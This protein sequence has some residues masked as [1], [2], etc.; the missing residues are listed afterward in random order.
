MGKPKTKIKLFLPLLLGF[1]IG[2]FFVGSIALALDVGLDYGTYTGLGTEDIRVSVMKIVRYFLGF[3]GIIALI[4]IIYGGFVWMTSA[5]NPEKVTLAKRILTSAVIGLVIILSAF[6]IVSFIINALVDTFVDPQTPICTPGDTQTCNVDAD[7]IGTQ[8]C[9][10]TGFWGSCIPNEP[11]SPECTNFISQAPN[12]FITTPQICQATDTI[13]EA[14]TSDPD[15]DTV[16]IEFTYISGV[17][18]GLIGSVNGISTPATI[19]SPPWDTSGFSIGQI[20]EVTAEVTDG[21]NS[22]SHARNF[23]I[24]AG[25]CC[26]GVQDVDEDGVDCGG[27]DC[28]GCS[29]ADCDLGD[30]DPA[31]CL[32]PENYNCYSLFCDPTGCT[33]QDKPMIFWVSP[34]D[35][36]SGNLVTIGGRYFGSIPGEVWFSGS[37]APAELADA[38]NPNCDSVWTDQQIIVVVPNDVSDGPIR[39]V[40]KT[41]GQDYEDQTNDDYGP[42][43]P[44]FD[45]NSIVRPGLCSVVNDNT[46]DPEGIF[47]DPLELQGINFSSG[48]DVF[49]G[50]VLSL[51]TPVVSGGLTIT[52]VNVPNVQP[53]P[54]IGTRVRDGG[55]YSNPVGFKVNETGKEPII[56]DFDPA[57]G[58]AGTYVTITGANF[59]TNRQ[60]VNGQ[61]YFE[62]VGIYEAEYDF[63]PEC[64]DSY[65]SDG[66]VVVKVPEG[67]NNASYTIRLSN[68]LGSASSEDS[69]VAD[70]GVVRPNICAVIPNNG[71]IDQNITI[72][73][74]G[75]FSPDVNQVNFYQNIPQ[76]SLTLDQIDRPDPE[77][78]TD[79]TKT[80]VPVS[81]LTGPVNIQNSLGNQSNSLN[82]IVGECLDDSGCETNY[83]CCLGGMYKGSCMP[84]GGCVGVATEAAYYWSF[85]TGLKPGPCSKDVGVCDPDNTLCDPGFECNSVTCECQA[86]P[87]FDCSKQPYPTCDP[88]DTLCNPDQYC[89]SN[90]TCQDRIACDGEELT[91]I[92]DPDQDICRQTLGNNWYCYDQATY[93][94]DPDKEDCYCYQGI[95]CD[96]DTE[97]FHYICIGGT[98]SGDFCDDGSGGSDPSI[99]DSGVCELDGTAPICDPNDDICQQFDANWVCGT[100][101]CIC[102]PG[103][104]APTEALYFWNFYSFSLGPQVVNECNRNSECAKVCALD[105]EKTCS[106]DSD[107]GA[108]GPCIKAFSSPTPLYSRDGEVYRNSIIS[109]SFDK[110]VI[111]NTIN[112][113]NIIIKECNVGTVFDPTSCSTVI[114]GDGDLDI[115]TWNYGLTESEGFIFT[116]NSPLSPNTWYQITLTQGIIGENG[117]PLGH[118]PNYTWEFKVLNTSNNGDIGCV[119]CQ[120]GYAVLWS[121][122]DGACDPDDLDC[123]D[124]IGSGWDQDNVCVM[125]DPNSYTWNWSLPTELTLERASILDDTS[126][127]PA[128]PNDSSDIILS[129]TTDETITTYS[130][131]EADFENPV[132]VQVQVPGVDDQA[133]FYGDNICEL[134]IDFSTPVVLKRWPDC[135][136][137][138]INAAMGAAFSVSIDPTTMTAG[139]VNSSMV[140][141]N[142]GDNPD[143]RPGYGTCSSSGTYCDLSLVGSDCPDTGET[144]LDNLHGIYTPTVIPLSWEEMGGKINGW[145]NSWLAATN[146][147]DLDGDGINDYCLLPNTYYKVILHDSIRGLADGKK[148]GGLNYCDAAIGNCDGS[149]FDSYT[150]TF[151]TQGSMCSPDRVRVYPEENWMRKEEINRYRSSAYASPDE[152]DP[153]GQPL[154]SSSFLWEWQSTNCQTADLLTNLELPFLNNHNIWSDPWTCTS[155]GTQGNP[156]FNNLRNGCGNGFIGQGEECDDGNVLSG[157]GCSDICLHEGSVS[158]GDF[159]EFNPFSGSDII[160]LDSSAVNIDGTAPFG[161]GSNLTSIFIFEDNDDSENILG[162]INNSPAGGTSSVAFNIGY[163]MPGTPEIVAFDDEQEYIYSKNY[164]FWEWDGGSDGALIKL[165]NDDW[166]VSISPA[167]WGGGNSW[168]LVIDGSPS[169]ISINTDQY[170]VVAKINGVYR[171]VISDDPIAPAVCG[172]GEVEIGEDCDDGNN[173]L[174]PLTGDYCNEN[175]LWAGNT[176]TFSVCGNGVVEP[177]EECDNGDEPN[178][179]DYDG[180]TNVCTNSGSV[181]GVS[182]CGDGLVGLGEECDTFS[183]TSPVSGDGCTGLDDPGNLCSNFTNELDCQ[184]N[185]KFCRWSANACYIRPCLD[186]S[187][188][189]IPNT[190]Y[191]LA[192]CG[193]GILESGEECDYGGVC[194]NS[195]GN[196]VTCS[197]HTQYSVCSSG[198]CGNGSCR[199][200]DDPSIWIDCPATQAEIDTLCYE[201]ICQAPAGFNSSVPDCSERCLNTGSVSDGKH[202][203]L[204]QALYDGETEIQSW[205]TIASEIVGWGDL[206]VGFPFG[207]GEFG[208]ID[209]WPDCSWACINAIIGAQFSLSANP[210][211]ITDTGFN[212]NPNSPSDPSDPGDKIL[213]YQCGKDE[214]CNVLN[215]VGVNINVTPDTINPDNPDDKFFISLPINY[216][217]VD[218]DNNPATPV[219]PTLVPGTFYRVVIR[220][221][222]DGVFS[223]DGKELKGLNFDDPLYGT[224]SG[225]DSYSWVFETQEEDDLCGLDHVEVIPKENTLPEGNVRSR[226]F[227]QPWSEP[228]QCDSRGQRL[229]PY[230]FQWVWQ[231]VDIEGINAA[232]F[233]GNGELDGCGNGIVD[234]GEDCDNGVVSDPKCS[235]S[236]EW[237]GNEYCSEVFQLD[238]CGNE[239]L[240]YGEECEIDLDNVQVYYSLEDNANDLMGNFDG[241]VFGDVSFN[242]GRLGQAAVFD[243]TPGEYIQIDNGLGQMPNTLK[244]QNELTVSAWVKPVSG[245]DGIGRVVATTY[246]HDCATCNHGGWI[247]GDEWGSDDS[248]SFVIWDNDG[249]NNDANRRIVS[250]SGFFTTFNNEWVHVAGVY[251]RSKGYISLYINGELV[252]QRLTSNFS[253]IGYDQVT[254]LRIGHRA[255]NETQGPWDGQIDDV[256]IY[257][258]ALSGIEIRNLANNFYCDGNCLAT[259][260]ENLNMAVCGN[261]IIEETEECDQGNEPNGNDTDGCTDVCR[262]SGSIPGV[263]SLCGDGV[264]GPGEECDE[265]EL[266]NG[267]KPVHLDD[268]DGDGIGCTG[269][270]YDNDAKYCVGGSNGGDPCNSNSDCDSN[271]CEPTGVV[272]QNECEAIDFADPNANPVCWCSWTGS[273]CQ[274]RPCLIEDRNLA[275]VCRSDRNNEFDFT[276]DPAECEQGYTAESLEF[277][278]GNANWD[279]P[280]CGNN[281]VEEGEQCDDGSWC[282]IGGDKW[283]RCNTYN[284]DKCEVPNSCKPYDGFCSID[285]SPC[286]LAPGGSLT[287]C[288]A[289]G[290]CDGNGACVT[291]NNNIPYSAGAVCGTPASPD[292]FGTACNISGGSCISDSCGINCTFNQS[293]AYDNMVDPYQVIQTVSIGVI[294]ALE[295]VKEEIR[296]WYNLQPDRVGVGELTVVSGIS[297]PFAVI[298]HKPPADTV[299]AG[300]LECRNVVLAATFSKPLKS[301]NIGDKFKLHLCSLGTT[302]SYASCDTN[303]NYIAQT[304]YSE[305]AG[306]CIDKTCHFSPNIVDSANQIFGACESDLECVASRVIVSEMY[307]YCSNDN[308]PCSLNSDCGSGN[309]CLSLGFL[310]P[311][312]SY[313]LVIDSSLEDISDETLGA[314]CSATDTSCE[315]DF[316]AGPDFCDCDYISLVVNPTSGGNETNEDYFTCAADNCGSATLTEFDDDVLDSALGNQHLWETTC[317][318][319]NNPDGRRIEISPV[320][321]NFNWSEFDPDDLIYFTDQS[322]GDFYNNKHYISPGEGDPY[323]PGTPAGKN[324]ESEVFIT[325]NQYYCLDSYQFCD[326][327]NASSCNGVQENCVGILASHKLVGVTNF[328]CDNPWPAAPNFPY[329]DNEDNGVSPDTNFKLFYCRDAGEEG[330]SDDLPALSLD[331]A[332][333]KGRGNVVKEFIFPSEGF[334]KEIKNEMDGD[335]PG[336]VDPSQS[337]CKGGSWSQLLIASARHASYCYNG[338]NPAGADPNYW[339][340]P[341]TADNFDKKGDYLL[342]ITTFSQSGDLSTLNYCDNNSDG[343]LKSPEITPC[344]PIDSNP[345]SSVGD[346]ITC[347]TG[348]R[349]I[350]KVFVDGNEVGQISNL[351]TDTEQVGSVI[352][353]NLDLGFH[354]V[355]IYWVNDWNDSINGYDSNLAISHIKLSRI[356]GAGVI[357]DAIGVRVLKNPL[358]LSPQTWYKSGLCGGGADFKNICFD[359][360]DCFQLRELGLAGY[361]SFDNDSSETVIDSSGNNFDGAVIGN[362]VISKMGKSWRFDGVDDGIDFGDIFDLGTDKSLTFSAWIKVEN[363]P[364]EHQDLIVGKK[365]NLYYYTTYYGLYVNK[366]GT[367]C[368][369]GITLS[370]GT[371][372]PLTSENI[373]SAYHED[374]L[375]DSEWHHVAGVIDRDNRKLRFY[376]DGQ[377]DSSNGNKDINGIL[378][379][380]DFSTLDFPFLIGKTYTVGAGDGPFDGYI[381]DVRVYDRALTSG[382]IQSLASR[383]YS[384]C[385]MNVPAQGSPSRTLTDNYYSIKDGRTV[386][387]G[388]TNRDL[389]NSE[390]YSNIYLLSYSQNSSPEIKEIFSRILDPNQQLGVWS[391]NTDVTNHRVCDGIGVFQGT[392]NLCTNLG[393]TYFSECSSYTLDRSSQGYV[394]SNGND[395]E[396]P[397]T[398]SEFNLPAVFSPDVGYYHPFN[399]GYVVLW[400]GS[401][402]WINDGTP[403]WTEVSYTTPTDGL[404]ANFDPEVGYYNDLA[405]GYVILWDNDQVYVADSSGTFDG[406]HDATEY[407]LPAGFSPDVGYY[408]PFDGGYV[409]LW[410]GDQAYIADSSGMFDGPHDATEYGLPP[411]FRPDVGYY[412]DFDGGRVALIDGSEIYVHDGTGNFDGPYNSEDFGLSPSIAPSIGY[413][414]PIDGGRVIIFENLSAGRNACNSDYVHG[415]YWSNTLNACLSRVCQPTYC[416]SDFDC[417]NL[418]CNAYK[419]EIVRD[420]KRYNDL[421]DIQILLESYAKQNQSYPVL[422]GGTYIPETS[423]STWPSWQI[424]LGQE[425]GSGLFTDPI[426]EMRACSTF[427]CDQNG[428]GVID[429]DTETGSFAQSCTWGNINDCNYNPFACMPADPDQELTCWD[430]VNENFTCPQEM[431]TYGY[432]PKAGGLDYGLYTFMEYDG[433]GNWR[434]ASV[435][436]LPTNLVNNAAGKCSILNFEIQSAPLGS[437]NAATTCVVKRCYGG[438]NNP[439]SP[440]DP[441]VNA[442]NTVSDCPDSTTPGVFCSGDADGDGV[443]DFGFTDNC[444]PATVAACQDN[445]SAC[446]NPN[447]RDTNSDGTGDVCDPNCSGDADGDGVC[448]EKDGCRTVANCENPALG[449]CNDCLGG[450]F[451]CTDNR[452][453]DHDNDEIPDACDPCTDIDKDGWWDYPTG[454]NDENICPRDNCAAGFLGV[455]IDNQGNRNGQRCDSSSMPCNS[456]YTCVEPLSTVANDRRKYCYLGNIP[457]PVSCDDQSDCN[458][459]GLS[460]ASCTQLSGN[461]TYYNPFQEDYD[462]DGVG[463]ICDTCIDFDNDNLGDYTFYTH[464]EGKPEYITND[465]EKHFMGCS[466]KYDEFKS[467]RPTRAMLD[468]NRDYNINNDDQ[469]DFSQWLLDGKPYPC[470]L[471]TC[472]LDKNGSV[473]NGDVTEWGNLKAILDTNFED[474][475]DLDNCPGGPF[476]ADCK[477]EFGVE[478]SCYNPP[479]SSWVDRFGEAHFNAQMDYDQDLLGSVCDPIGELGGSGT[480]VDSCGDGVVDAKYG[481]ICDCGSTFTSP[482]VPLNQDTSILSICNSRNN[483]PC[484]APY[485]GSCQWCSNCTQ[486]KIVD[487]GFCGDNIAQWPNEVCDDGQDPTN[488]SCNDT[489]TGWGTINGITSPC[490]DDINNYNPWSLE[491]SDSLSGPWSGSYTFNTNDL[492]YMS[493]PDCSTIFDNISL[494]ITGS[495]DLAYRPT[496]AVVFVTDLSGSMGDSMTELKISLQ[497]AI[498]SLFDGLNDTVEVGLVSYSSSA[499]KD[500]SS[501]SNFLCDNTEESVLIGSRSNNSDGIV[502]NYDDGGATRTDQAVSAAEE[503]LDSVSGFDNKFM[504]VM[505]DGG[506]SCRGNDCCGG[507]I[508]CASTPAGC[509]RVRVGGCGLLGLL[510]DYEFPCN[511]TDEAQTARSGGLTIYSV[512]YGGDVATMN[513]VSSNSEIGVST[514]DNNPEHYCYTSNT[515]LTGMYTTIV[516][517]IINSQGGVSLNLIVNEG[518]SSESSETFTVSGNSIDFNDGSFS[519]TLNI[520]FSSTFCENQTDPTFSV[521]DINPVCTNGTPLHG[522]LSTCGPSVCEVNVVSVDPTFHYCPTCDADWD[523]VWN[524]FCNGPDCNDNDPNIPSAE[525]CDDPFAVDE[526]CDGAINC[527]DTD[528]ASLPICESNFSVSGSKGKLVIDG[529]IIAGAFDSFFCAAPLPPYYCD[530]DSDGRFSKKISGRASP[531]PSGCQGIIG[532]DCDDTNEN[533]NPGMPELCGSGLDED[534][535]GD[536]D[537]DDIDCE[538]DS[539]C[540]LPENCSNGLDDDEDGYVDCADFD[541]TGSVDG[542]GRICCGTSTGPDNNLCNTCQRCVD[543]TTEEEA[544]SGERG[545][546]NTND[547]LNRCVNFNSDEGINCTGDSCTRCV[548]GSCV[549]RSDFDGT[550]CTGTDEVCL[551]G[552]CQVVSCIPGQI[553]DCPLTQGVCAG[554]QQN[555]VAG[556]WSICDAATYGPDYEATETSCNDGLDND[557]DGDTDTCQDSDCPTE[558]TEVSCTDTINNDCDGDADCADSD[559]SADPACLTCPDSVCE[560]GEV[561]SLDC[562]TET[563]CSDS[564]D[565]DNDG[566]QDTADSDCGGS[567]IN[568]V[569]SVDNDCDGYID[570]ADSN[571]TGDPACITCPNGTCAE[572]E[573]CSADC[574]TE[575]WC[576]DNVDNDN[577]TCED[578]VDVDCGGTETSCNDT[579]D[580]DCDGNTDCADPDCSGDPACVTCPNGTC[581]FGEICPADCTEDDQCSDGEDNDSNGCTDSQ[582]YLCGGTETSCNDTNDNDCDGNTDCADPDCSGDPACLATYTLSTVKLGTGL[583]DVSSVPSGINCGP[584]CMEV[585]TEGTSVTLSATPDG[586]SIFSG[587]TGGGCSGTGDCIF[588]INNDT[589]I[590]ATFDTITY[591]LSVSTSGSGSVSSVPSGIN[592]GADCSEAYNISTNVNLTAVPGGSSF[593]VNWSGDCSGTD[594]SNCS[595]TMNSNHNVTANFGSC[596]DSDSDGYSPEGGFCGLT[597]CN[598]DPII[599]SNI[600]PTNS[601]IYCDCAGTYSQG[602]TE[603]CDGVDNDCDGDV[604]EGCAGACTIGQ[605]TSCSSL[606]FAGVCASPTATCDSATG[607]WDVSPCQIGT[608][609]I[610]DD[611]LDN[612]CMNGADCADLSCVGSAGPTGDLC[613]LDSGDCNEYNGNCVSKI[614]DVGN[615]NTCS[616]QSQNSLCL[617]NCDQCVLSG[618]SYNCQANSSLC[619]GDCAVC[620]E[621]NSVNFTCEGN[622]TLCSGECDWCDG[623]GTNFTCQNVAANT[624]DIYGNS[625][626]LCSDTEGYGGCTPPCYCNSSGSCIAGSDADNDGLVDDFDPCPYDPNNDWDTANIASVNDQICAVGC[627]WYSGAPAPFDD[628]S[629]IKNNGYICAP[630]ALV[631]YD[632]C[633]GGGVGECN[634]TNSCRVWF[635]AEDFLNIYSYNSSSGNEVLIAGNLY[636]PDGFAT[637][638]EVLGNSTPI[639]FIPNIWSSAGGFNGSDYKF[640]FLARSDNLFVSPPKVGQI[641]GSFTNYNSNGEC[642]LLSGLIYK[643]TKREEMPLYCEGLLSVS[644][645]TEGSSA[646][647]NL[648]MTP[649]TPAPV[650]AFGN[651]EEIYCQTW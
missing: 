550:E 320:G 18:G 144:C 331:A 161:L 620:Q 238:C 308:K 354:E 540:V 3:L 51:G 309:E 127:Q 7:C 517:N 234:A 559:C 441:T 421:R 28:I 371:V 463:Y 426:N 425:L 417:P 97:N 106:D 396:G 270:Y 612:D 539:L 497:N 495:V 92:C 537:C 126:P 395:F 401:S 548:N 221:G 152:C 532:D 345:C 60:Q 428:N 404:P 413:Y 274:T 142:C 513:T 576:S 129:L 271:N 120:P 322:V 157:D 512:A 172:N 588:T 449:I 339:S 597:D 327:L 261:G 378:N 291:N 475:I 393:S 250:D 424:T 223:A 183:G 148:L 358:R 201:N 39:I 519:T 579:N 571:C 87:T 508:G 434:D 590:S 77:I 293:I 4:I 391:F 569:D 534:C 5:G 163:N 204:V 563:W 596:S 511:P 328:I 91:P 300:V 302:G 452:Q 32:T 356:E 602:T 258:K 279:L 501:C 486:V 456:G 383:A 614:C 506:C 368:R 155:T 364:D 575:T 369:S 544:Y 484:P 420:S 42:F 117:F 629:G 169:L 522:G 610:C 210:D 215:A 306:S 625:G 437:T 567:E 332:V 216:N 574:I 103:G 637:E 252:D 361:W 218:H 470:P 429:L 525:I 465:Q 227:S 329:Y 226:Y 195:W 76:T 294:P 124:Y 618:N 71:P 397:Y 301:T 455:C 323:D 648:W 140:V 284:R 468:F 462:N 286:N 276:Q 85:T 533:I 353:P 582:D 565:N 307:G 209:R 62:G 646:T 149:E 246:N 288:T 379:N 503:I 180:C 489:C 555:C 603:T 514:C 10:G 410:Q 348:V 458:A 118:N 334:K 362:P 134:L 175:C 171:Y 584:D 225:V 335:N 466:S 418:N 647:E 104:P 217:P 31:T 283:M 170:L 314:S 450:S 608:I 580:N 248:F 202:N 178:Y 121:R 316:S 510:D 108:D 79:L 479:I 37:S 296:A 166:L 287:P 536:I 326:P 460:G 496:T 299:P 295:R 44:D 333:I 265:G 133:Y 529:G 491:F 430:E 469:N 109:A 581:E 443:C 57:N 440:S 623:S 125:L 143:C 72:Y 264:V 137:A 131:F 528:C 381:D 502:G 591:I 281:I 347:I 624:Q 427:F 13:I 168:Q 388:A 459:A 621:V 24:R 230:F 615:T 222:A 473:D 176:D 243:A 188:T 285:A 289:T 370:D 206:T 14:V 83:E 600:Y 606:G 254:P 392:D 6:M 213:L 601:N 547:D 343:I 605:T 30:T 498:I 263:D 90:C 350:L 200:K 630:G 224:S 613:C 240:E 315:W 538:F 515:D 412:H 376:L 611:N 19:N 244:Y 504:I 154:M 628:G 644:G 365:Q 507:L 73:G 516:N 476:G 321:I 432:E 319:T 650:W 312:S 147:Y 66:Q 493:A 11:D 199:K 577:D 130:R 54:M 174:N 474:E 20:V 45:L 122:Y 595:L 84:L 36:A 153:E 478:V 341:F 521:K 363:C 310:A 566:C 196:L 359:N 551:G 267:D 33:C 173:F 219:Q 633:Q 542:S 423:F 63:P 94:V 292:A 607:N 330:F 570:C 93:G 407:G 115:F 2:S 543:D 604:D 303:N 351:A 439:G 482:F 461:Y 262:F 325:A 68:N 75:F 17:S 651:P 179:D 541:C 589:S 81:S 416:E 228:D 186:E 165:T 445:P 249:N 101:T 649:L 297:V 636:L 211:D 414:H 245:P 451:G 231:D 562:T 56:Y 638:G 41:T 554:S 477:D 102:E 564:V 38:V 643:R 164:L 408:H 442:C 313:H 220:G 573:V 247:L 317:Y 572:G 500:S 114:S 53:A 278:V 52:G 233:I 568:C 435:Y 520:D 634:E 241:Q 156:N 139:N 561:C 74:E 627:G 86:K 531:A 444:N 253:G 237:I 553:Q 35:G 492:V 212:Y 67:I 622:H 198:V 386:Y 453:I 626:Q 641:R 394:S 640:T 377:L 524:A 21:D 27:A 99:C 100:D 447:Q 467:F 340:P 616:Y 47:E 398:P 1:V 229:N 95:P 185:D 207:E 158:I 399:G 260:N 406:P 55:E 632:T 472:D 372:P 190:N 526:D 26:N 15:L 49:L 70:S 403:G 411:G 305:Y 269:I 488:P 61:V 141:Y 454:A 111:D 337:V 346:D 277:V 159:I 523:G 110:K 494:N 181:P 191:S 419:E 113:S 25:H 64:S 128:V 431:L 96:L 557:C 239:D 205:T 9:L 400:Q 593:F 355:K 578:G 208:V 242:D 360:N 631:S 193:N 352:L 415:C 280:I 65:W 123:Q 311:N 402:A 384:Q 43:L 535:D 483:L 487:G 282:G 389:D 214:T 46:G 232:D 530:N 304:V 556:T 599:G 89:D 558:P 382:E 436:D 257:N 138:C 336:L 290:Y 324:G 266:V 639:Y 373:Q 387:V 105:R 16:N 357:N 457:Y 594:P 255:D 499:S 385:V 251:S 194:V 545:S 527:Q 342:E 268:Y 58:A 177:G 619:I 98:N 82:F 8:S 12:V 446:Y 116:P 135:G 509:T 23:S 197:T 273:N 256:K 518:Q 34:N 645:G 236:C 375:D 259:G 40:E 405:G 78:D 235:S 136:A 367:S 480:I 162:I 586:T 485:N 167:F 560:E 552:F 80:N 366:V 433:V 471:S 132:N 598:E 481:E 490:G 145:N 438:S 275:L 349:H 374:L 642:T 187:D 380:F 448:N 338:S 298:G 464:E 119:G 587:W 160:L 150:W 409:V 189:A 583:G 585:Y 50:Q 318:D 617:G 107:C 48:S 112:S 390:L 69:F 22:F 272:T 546:N 146:C 505:S 609:E 151:R 203:Q 192:S 635:G 88:A 549:A 182:I 184:A 29:G 59:G 344:N 592:C 422:S